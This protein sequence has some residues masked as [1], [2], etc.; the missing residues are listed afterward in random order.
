MWPTGWAQDGERGGLSRASIID[1]NIKTLMRPLHVLCVA[2]SIHGLAKEECRNRKGTLMIIVMFTFD[3][4]APRLRG[5]CIGPWKQTPLSHPGNQALA[6][7]ILCPRTNGP[8]SFLSSTLPSSCSSTM[9]LICTL[10]PWHEQLFPP[11]YFQFLVSYMFITNLLFY[12]F[13]GILAPFASRTSSSRTLP[14][15]RFL[16]TLTFSCKRVRNLVGANWAE[17]PSG[18]PRGPSAFK[19]KEIGSAQSRREQC[20]N[21]QKIDT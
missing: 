2:A 16:T 7:G 8:P 18:G 20:H 10:Q 19:K 17:L 14:C 13:K 11:D 5:G 4:V 1:T 9:R 21:M 6:Q 15:L 3:L 12:L